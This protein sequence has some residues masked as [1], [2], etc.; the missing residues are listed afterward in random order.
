MN[1][2]EGWDRMLPDC[3]VTHHTSLNP[4]RDTKKL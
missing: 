1:M 3:H 2:V 4:N